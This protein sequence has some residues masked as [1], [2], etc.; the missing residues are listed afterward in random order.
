MGDTRE[1]Q[2]S[3]QDKP[4]AQ[5]RMWFA[6]KLRPESPA[7]NTPLAYLLEGPISLTALERSVDALKWKAPACKPRISHSDGTSREGGCRDDHC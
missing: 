7:H 2:C 5:E 3:P 4:I 6:H 1:P